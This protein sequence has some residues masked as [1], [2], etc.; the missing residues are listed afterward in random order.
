M[1][2]SSIFGWLEFLDRRISEIKKQNPV[3]QSGVTGQHTEACHLALLELTE[4]LESLLGSTVVV[5]DRRTSF[6]AM[7]AVLEHIRMSGYVS[8]DTLNS[9]IASVVR[10]SSNFRVVSGFVL[11]PVNMTDYGFNVFPVIH[12]VADW[13]KDLF[14][15]VRTILKFL[16][17]DGTSQ[18]E[19]WTGRWRGLGALLKDLHGCCKR[20]LKQ[21][22]FR[23]QMA[24]SVS[25]YTDTTDDVVETKV[26]YTND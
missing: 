15:D 6:E 21:I 10:K 20:L 17:A 5:E 7:E 18:A 25:R 22:H 1:Y 12:L 14:G 9:R 2:A 26:R 8:W 24:E 19:K 23:D 3:S 13:I 4:Q 16:K 11:V